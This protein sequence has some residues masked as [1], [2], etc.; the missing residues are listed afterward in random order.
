[1]SAHVLRR[2]RTRA[3]IGAAIGAATALVSTAAPVIRPATAAVPDQVLIWNQLAM[4]DLIRAGAQSPPVATL[5][6]AM[7]HGAVYDAV[8]AIT[9]THQPYLAAPTAESSDS[10]DAAAATA[11]WRV[12][13]SLT[14]DGGRLSQLDSRYSESLASIPDGDAETGGIRAGESAAAAM[15]AARTG[16]GRFGAPL[17]TVGSAPGQWRPVP[18]NNFRWIGEVKPF[19]VG[20]AARFATDGPLPMTSTQYAAEFEEVRTLGRKTGSSRTEDQTAQALFWADHTTAMWTRIA[21]QLA[22]GQQLSTAENARYFAMLYLTTADSLIAC[23]QDKER[24]QFWRP[25][26]AIQE[27]DHDGNPATTAEPGWQP[28]IANPPYPD[29]PS[30]ANCAA[31]GMAYTLRDFF[32]TNRMSFSATHATTGVTRSF[33]QFSDA[34][35]EV[36]HARVYSGL[37]FMTADAAG[38]NIGKEVARYRDR[39]AFQPV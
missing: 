28:L 15:I 32:G 23:F 36:R 13:R 33:K 18:G 38:A 10:I 17:F 6:L 24:H 27:A 29:H 1:M 35:Q 19:V 31:G 21:R 37:H 14:T 9:R 4:D 16:D 22:V 2:H 3:L 5:H 12:L 25:Q 7:V 20:D 26:T 11:A 34:L 39:H 8:N 30:G